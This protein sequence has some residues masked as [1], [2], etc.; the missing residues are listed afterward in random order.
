[1]ILL[2]MNVK[3]IISLLALPLWLFQAERSFSQIKEKTE[4]IK[5]DDTRI[6][7]WPQTFS[8]VKIPGTDNTVQ[9]AYFYKSTSAKLQPLIVSLHTWGGNY[10]QRDDIALL[11]AHKNYNYIHPDFR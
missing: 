4:I 7:T 9:N 1:Y 3:Q 2:L 8:L 6:F 11:S 10:A 5:F